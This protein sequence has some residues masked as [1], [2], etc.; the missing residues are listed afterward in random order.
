MSQSKKSG[1]TLIELLVVISIIALLLGILVPVLGAAKK[2][3][4]I[5]KEGANLRN[6]HA[7]NAVYGTA[8]KDFFPGL[9]S[10]GKYAGWDLGTLTSGGSAADFIGKY[11]AA[12]TN[13]ASLT[14]AVANIGQTSNYAQAVIL[15]EGATTG[16]QWISTGETNVTG[17]NTIMTIP[18]VQAKPPTAGGVPTTVDNSTGAVNQANNSYAQLAYGSA[19]LKPEWKSNQ[20]QMALVFGSRVIGG[21]TGLDNGATDGFN[22]VWTDYQSGVFKGSLVRGD[23]SSSV[24]NFKRLTVRDAFGTL[25]YGSLAG[26]YANTASTA[27]VGPYGAVDVTTGAVTYGTAASNFGGSLSAGVMITAQIGSQ[28]N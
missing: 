5:M 24:E 7:A 13:A 4:N 26:T 9:T 19:S 6:V 8:N 23:S 14:S 27:L 3:A 16:E 21:T 28:N 18:T 2:N 22:T 20:N 15:D 11:Y 25:K 1:F 12:V 17:A 10:S